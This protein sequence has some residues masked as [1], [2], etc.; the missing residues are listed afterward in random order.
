MGAKKEGQNINWETGGNERNRGER[1][2]GEKKT[3][4]KNRFKKQGRVE[5]EDRGTK[6]S[7]FLPLTS[8]L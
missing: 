3:E 8:K 4:E 5:A 2:S 7:L 6:P 1:K